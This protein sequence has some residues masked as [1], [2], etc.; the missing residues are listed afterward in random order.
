MVDKKRS[1]TKSNKKRQQKK[2]KQRLFLFGLILLVLTVIGV[3]LTLSVLSTSMNSLST[4]ISRDTTDVMLTSAGIGEE[5]TTTIPVSYYDQKS[6][7]C[8]NF[9]D[10]WNEEIISSRQFEWETCG[11]KKSEIEK[12]LVEAKLNEKYLPV[13]IGGTFLSNRGINGTNFDRW[14]N[15]VDGKSKSY[16]GSLV[17]NHDDE[18]VSFKYVNDEFYPLDEYNTW[19]EKLTHDKHNHLFTMNLGIPFHVTFDGNEKFKIIADDDTWVF[20]NDELVLDMGGIH[21]ATSGAFRI[22]RN[23]EV[24][25]GPDERSLAYSG[26]KLADT[27]S[28]IIRVFHADRN[29]KDSVFEM[30]LVNMLLNVSKASLAQTDNTAEVAYNPEDPSYVAPLGESLY[31]RPNYSNTMAMMVTTQAAILGVLMILAVVAISLVWRYSRHGRNS[32][33]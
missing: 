17:L 14:F 24:Y 12:N 6:D 13:A 31:I 33:K 28:A 23:G 32:A 29:S 15:Q 20:L 3:S 7:E 19:N 5:F 4:E 18:A 22:M 9:Y 30:E 10:V 11:Y 16:A 21:D 25:A 8:V 2:G 27:D 26:I 1:T